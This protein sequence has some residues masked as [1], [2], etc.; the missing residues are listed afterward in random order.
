M[1]LPLVTIDGVDNTITSWFNSRFNYPAGTYIITYLYGA[2]S[3]NPLVNDP[4]GNAANTTDGAGN[5]IYYSCSPSFG[6]PNNVSQAAV[7]AA[8]GGETVNYVHVGG[9]IGMY[10]GDGFTNDNQHGNPDPTFSLNIT[11]PVV[12]L[13]TDVVSTPCGNTTTGVNLSWTALTNASSYNIY[14]STTSGSGYILIGNTASSSFTDTPPQIFPTYYY[15]VTGLFSGGESSYSNEVSAEGVLAITPSVLGSIPNWFNGGEDYP[16]GIYRICYVRGS[17]EYDPRGFAAGRGSTVNANYQIDNP[18]PLGKIA[19][20]YVTDG[21]DNEILAPGN[22]TLYPNES[23]CEA[24][25]SGSSVIYNHNGGKIGVYLNDW[26]YWDNSTNAFG[27]TFTISPQA[28]VITFSASPLGPNR[29][30]TSVT[31]LWSC[32][33]SPASVTI[34]NGIGSVSSSGS[35]VVNP[36]T[37]TTYV[38]TAVS[39]TPPNIT[40]MAIVKVLVGAIGPIL[41]LTAQGNCSGNALIA[42][43]SVP[44]SASYKV[45]RAITQSGNFSTIATPSVTN[46]TDTPPDQFQAYDYKVSAY[47]GLNYGTS[48]LVQGVIAGGTPNAPAS[49]AAVPGNGNVAVSAN[50]VES[51]TSYNLWRSIS[52]GSETLYQTGL[53]LPTYLDSGLQNGQKYFYKWYA[54]SSCGTSVASTEVSATPLLSLGIWNPAEPH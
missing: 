41:Y 19:G 22:T 10:C 29:E 36:S 42:W 5:I 3:Y 13:T 26:P 52:S 11:P 33:N 47:D 38:L 39:Q 27:P 1:S 18:T 7:E 23:G 46:Y 28:S 45:E 21:N 50:Q 35:T 25:N 40:T 30:G 9:N 4:W 48:A 12:S 53:V 16:S 20:F 14:R 6:G 43:G 44:F 24:G 54:V 34:D 37:T 32:T 51:A 31:L 8:F 49:P 15:V 17:Y 2:F